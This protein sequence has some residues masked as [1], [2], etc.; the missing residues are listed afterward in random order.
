M[1]S[2]LLSAEIINLKKIVTDAIDN[3]E[4]KTEFYRRIKELEHKD[5]SNVLNV[6]VS[7]EFNSGKSTFIN[8]LL[9][10]RLLKEA[11][12][13][14]TAAATYICKAKPR[15][16]F[17]FLKKPKNSVNVRFDDGAYFEFD[18]KHISEIITHIRSHYGISLEMSN[19]KDVIGILTSE[20][21]VSRHV[22]HIELHL[23]NEV[24][25][26]NFNIID[27]PGF[28]PGTTTFDNHMSIAR[29]VVS[30]IA[31]MAI[32]LMP[33]NQAM[34]NSLI[35]FLQE[36]SI[37]RYL[38]RCIF[39]ITKID[40]IEQY[41][42]RS[43]I[44]FVEQNLKAMGVQSPK[45]YT[46]SA[47]CMLPVVR[48]PESL[49]SEWSSF[50]NRFI[51]MENE[52]WKAV[53]KYRD[54]AIYEHCLNI[55]ADIAKE[56]SSSINNN[57]TLQREALTILQNN[58][59]RRIQELTEEE[60]KKSSIQINGY[61]SSL[62]ISPSSYIQRAESKV[63]SI[64]HSGGKLRHFRSIELPKIEQTVKDVTQ[65]YISYINTQ[66]Q[67]SIRVFTQQVESF[68]HVF[69]SHYR[70]MPALEPKMNYESTKRIS[71]KASYKPSSN[72]AVY[73]LGGVRH[74]FGSL[75]K[76]ESEIQSAA[77]S[78]VNSTIGSYFYELSKIIE[79][80]KFTIQRAQIATLKSY[81]DRHV[82]QYGHR[83]NSLIEE[84]T[85]Q[86]NRLTT[87]IDFYKAKNIEISN[88]TRRI[89]AELRASMAQ[90]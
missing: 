27:T 84:Q 69:H 42:R 34:S 13:P 75:I 47:I 37:N 40:S 54:I 35:S 55:L 2:E 1:P 65:E 41:E 71:A 58:T 5:K 81:C 18:E 88:I 52:I 12:R 45:I 63:V 56:I 24:L 17:A 62:N 36:E 79:E 53:A 72:E 8:A 83:V 6:A 3:I 25:P 16:L 33:A 57:I 31:D 26:D 29:T 14:T 39:I 11:V 61:F 86:K 89:E 74:W 15:G 64:I 66:L 48:I 7:G 44:D 60:F 51:L 87:R 9:R 46:T 77:V 38:H 73:K 28:N 67:G 21:M 76:S 80:Q 50:Q 70:D 32:I 30:N 59:V 19:I 22:T 43:I 10:E 68:K 20:Q 90:T 49:R 85:K 78:D 4:Q 82:K 23:K